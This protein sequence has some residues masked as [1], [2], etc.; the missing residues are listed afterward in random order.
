MKQVAYR[1]LQPPVQFAAYLLLAW[2]GRPLAMQVALGI[3]FPVVVL[4][5]PELTPCLKPG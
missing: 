3:N 5:S 2:F 4:L 1:K